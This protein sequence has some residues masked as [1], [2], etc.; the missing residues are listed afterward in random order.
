MENENQPVLGGKPAAKE[1]PL[2]ATE[3]PAAEEAPAEPAVEQP[4][5]PVVERPA[6]EP[7]PVEQPTV[8]DKPKKKKSKAWI[9]ILI[10]LLLIGAGVA[11][12]FLFFF[13]KGG[14]ELSY[15]KKEPEPEIYTS[16]EKLANE[17]AAGVITVGEYVK[18]LIYSEYDTSKLDE[19]YKAD[20]GAISDSKVTDILE[21]IEKNSASIDSSV[22]NDFINNYLL[23]G[24][25]LGAGVDKVSQAE[26]DIT[27]AATTKYNTTLDKAVLSEDGNFL[28]WYTESGANKATKE[29]ATNLAKNLAANVKTYNKI[30][31]YNYSFEPFTLQTKSAKSARLAAIAILAANNIPVKKLDT[32]MSVYIIKGNSDALASYNPLT[33]DKGTTI[34]NIITS[35][36]TDD[37]MDTG[38]FNFP[39][40]LVNLSA[41]EKGAEGA[42]QA[43][44]HELFH[45]YQMEIICAGNKSEKAYYNYCSDDAKNNNYAEATANYFSAKVSTGSDSEL[46]LNRWAGHYSSH[47]YE[48]VR[49]IVNGDGVHGYGEFPYL[50][51]YEKKVDNGLTK[52]INAIK[53][54]DPYTYLQFNGGTKTKDAMND[55]AYRAI[56]KDY[57]L[58]PIKNTTQPTYENDPTQSFDIKFQLPEGAAQF[59][60]LGKDWSIEFS[61]S[62]SYISANVIGKKG[63]KYTVLSTKDGSLSAKSGDYSDYDEYFLAVANGNIL[64]SDFYKLKL[65]KQDAPNTINLNTKYKNYDVDFTMNISVMGIDMT[66]TGSG[67]VDEKHQRSYL[68]STVSSIMGI[69]ME[70][71]TYSD[72]YN[73][74]SYYTNPKTSMSGGFGDL[75]KLFTGD[76]EPAWLKMSSAQHTVDI[77]LVAKKLM[78]SKDTEKLSNGHYKIKMTSKELNDLM[79]VANSSDDKDQKEIAINTGLVNVEVEIDDFGHITKIDYDFSSVM[80]GVDKATCTMKLSNYNYAGDIIIP[81]SVRYGAVEE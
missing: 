13:N 18:Q 10:A 21:L 49:N 36:A 15:E 38:S 50:Y 25:K 44:N 4:A 2:W 42:G 60:T 11:V 28:I 69:G 54:D 68:K 57:D 31:G 5:E 80:E 22:I 58:D 75:I 48:G 24:V 59:F 32:A 16:A 3:K 56:S 19:K 81:E 52:I 74:V 40:I 33:C 45:H 79:Q 67:R 7:A 29:Q 8:A 70:M 77:G 73:G 65:E 47:L 76:D 46:F 6:E 34:C 71:I 20:E 30:T 53:E 66:A 78:T 26:N 14:E 39:Y 12:F 17:Y 61:S 1:Q 41:L 63:E 55:A 64:K 43:I 72:F 27:L 35:L 62:N 51:S 37:L 23:V 9:F